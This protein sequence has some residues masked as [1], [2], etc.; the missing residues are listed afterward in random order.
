[1][2]NTFA[3]TFYEMA[4]SDDRLVV[5]VA[6][7]SPAGSIA[8]FRNEFPE[9]FINT[10]VAEQVMIG[11]CAGMA[12]KGLRPFAYTIATFSVF[13][14]YE[15]IRDDLC[16][17]DLPVSIV[18][19]G[20][21][22]S[23]STLGSTHHAMEDVAL[24]TG[25]P[26]MQVLAPCDPVETAA[27]T[28]WLATKSQHP[29]YLRLGKAGEPDISSN[30]EEPWEFGRIRRLRR[31]RHTAFLS[32]GPILARLVTIADRMES[33]HGLSPTVINVST[34]KPLDLDGIAKVLRSHEEVVVVE[35]HVPRGGLASY[36]KELAWDI[37][38][39]CALKCFTLKDEFLHVYGAHEDLLSA[40]GLDS[41]NIA[42]ALTIHG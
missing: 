21:G 31:G 20:G 12:Q 34:L 8:Q 27:A 4:T 33:C 13:R 7:I 26:N 36:V 14:P 10:G 19:I 42:K 30:A 1:M 22:V 3:S 38:A 32:Y 9:R 35:E 11:L 16:Y 29:A 25:L 15:M 24:M 40:H 2:R 5:V 41:D 37:R 39:S 23:Y 6:D 28:R 18:G 17:Q